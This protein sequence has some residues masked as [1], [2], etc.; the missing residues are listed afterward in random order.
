[1]K[2]IKRKLLAHFLNVGTADSPDY[3]LIGKGVTSATIAYNP[4]TSDETY[5][6]EDTG[7]TDVESYKPNMPVPMTAYA[8]EPVFDFVDNLRKTRAVM[9]DARAELV[10]VYLYETAETGAYP[11]EK[12]VVSVQIDD[13]GGDGG[14]R[15]SINFTLNYCGDP[16]QGTFN[17]ETKTFTE[18]SA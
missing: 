4:Q 9:D 1:M 8:G 16:V 5:I 14:A 11:A 15:A 2:A 18:A 17:P 12:N 6:N 3:E 13:F 10:N 7:T